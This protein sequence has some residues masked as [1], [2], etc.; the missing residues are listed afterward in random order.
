METNKNKQY[1]FK[2]YSPRWGHDDTYLLTLKEKGWR[3]DFLSINGDCDKTGSPYLFANLDHDSIEYPSSLGFEMRALHEAAWDGE[4]DQ[5]EI[6]R[7]LDELGK[8]VGLVDQVEKP[9]FD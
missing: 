3:V 1:K 4:I 5:V 7:R 6:Q 8:W 9:H 2:V